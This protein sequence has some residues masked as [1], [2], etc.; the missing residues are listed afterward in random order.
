MKEISVPS[1]FLVFLLCFSSWEHRS[2]GLR[3]EKSS[4]QHPVIGMA[5]LVFLRCL[6]PSD[7]LHSGDD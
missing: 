5:N 3:P 1:N 7:L 2:T 6:P 4:P